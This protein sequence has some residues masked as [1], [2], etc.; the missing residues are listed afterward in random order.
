MDFVL[1]NSDVL[2]RIYKDGRVQV[3]EIPGRNIK[4]FFPCF[5]DIHTQKARAVHSSVWAVPWHVQYDL[6]ASL[7]LRT[8]GFH[9]VLFHVGFVVDR[10]ALDRPSSKHF[11]FTCQYH[12]TNAPYTLIYHRRYVIVAVWFG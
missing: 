5:T 12:S 1:T 11:R 2:L 8:T 10:V 7:C 9:A 4:T 3:Q 6:V